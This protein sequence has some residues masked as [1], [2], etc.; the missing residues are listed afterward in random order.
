MGA[1][2]S[3]KKP[4]YCIIAND[5]KEKVEK[6]EYE[7]GNLL[8]TESELCEIYGVSRITVRKSMERLEEENVIERPFSKTPMIKKAAIPRDIN[9]L[10]SLS[11]DLALAGTKC[12]NYIL[13]AEE[14]TADERLAGKMGV[15]E[16][17]PLYLIERLRYGN[18]DPL[19]YQTT[20]LLKR[21]C[22]G[23]IDMDLAKSSIY[24]LLE[25]K[26]HL[27]IA[28]CEEKI[29]AC[30]SSYRISA[31]LELPEHSAILKVVC[32]G[33]LK[34]KTCFEYSINRYVGDNYQV[35][36]TLSRR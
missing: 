5:I 16:G 32:L 28:N 22:P 34:D 8:P 4:L 3:G 29:S 23:F 12:S 1:T 14:T 20:Y 35:T 30:T 13:K 6:G 21:L 26:Y 11:E 24:H 27:E 7:A 31:L 17:E 25:S 18:G 9:Q 33:Y 36:V 2:R 10:R 19:C 15:S